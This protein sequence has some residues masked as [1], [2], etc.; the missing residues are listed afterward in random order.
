M[1]DQDKNTIQQLKRA[2]NELKRENSYLKERQ[3]R[4]SRAE[5]VSEIAHLVFVFNYMNLDSST[6]IESV[7]EDS[8]KFCKY[9][10]E[11]IKK[12]QDE[13]LFDG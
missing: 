13:E 1:S 4:R 6:G 11:Y 2:N 8:E 9:R 7:F 12:K 5:D 3:N 10:D